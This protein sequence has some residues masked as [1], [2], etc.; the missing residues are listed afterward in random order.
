MIKYI[1]LLQSIWKTSVSVFFTVDTPDPN[2]DAE[3]AGSVRHPAFEAEDIISLEKK[4]L[5][6]SAGGL[7]KDPNGF[8]L[9]FL[10]YGKSK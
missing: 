10:Q 2:V 6:V 7:I 4:L 3:K 5:E 1:D 8:E 9:E